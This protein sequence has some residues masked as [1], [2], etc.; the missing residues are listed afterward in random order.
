MSHKRIKA[1]VERITS[2]TESIIQL[3]LIPEECIP[4]EAGQYLQILSGDDALSY[5]IANAPLEAPYYELHIRQ[6]RDNPYNQQL[7][8]QIKPEGEVTLLLPFGQCSVDQLSNQ[9]PIVFIA[10]GTGF[11]PVK[12]MIESLLAKDDPRQLELY[13]GARTSSDLYFD[14]Q[15]R[16]WETQ[17]TRFKYFPLLSDESKTT[18][19]SLVLDNHSKDLNLWQMVISGPFDMVYSIRDALVA[20]G[21]P[22]EQLFSDAFSFEGK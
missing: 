9:R 7:M 6:S 5:S 11:A 20:Q 14:Q 19:A 4:Y 12:A 2:L 15:V 13:W 3:I 8:A 17:M 10:G 18:L 1:R 21:M 22:V 16:T